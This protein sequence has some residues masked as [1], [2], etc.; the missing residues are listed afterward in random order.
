MEASSDLALA[1]V[2][3]RRPVTQAWLT[4]TRFS[5]LLGLMVI[6]AFSEVIFGGRSFFYRDFGLWAYPNAFHHR[7]RFWTGEV[8]LWNP[9]SSCGI[10][11]LAQWNTIT[12]YPFSLIYLLLPLPWSLNVFCLA[13]LWLAGLGMY[14]LALR[15]TRQPLAAGIAGLA[16]GL[17]GLTLHS[18]M[19]PNNLAALGWAPLVVLC[20]ERAWQ[21]GGRPIVPAAVLAATQ[22]LAGAPE[23]LLFTWCLLFAL[24]GADVLRNRRARLAPLGRFV[25]IA[26]LALGLSSIQLLPFVQLVS[27]S[28]RSAAF[29]DATWSM[30][31]WGVANFLVPLFHETKSVV[32]VYSQD[33]QQWT[34]SYY[35]GVGPL[36]LAILAL[37]RTNDRRTK[38]LAGLAAFGLAMSMG[39]NTPLFGWMKSLFPPLGMVRFPIKFV[40]LVVLTVPL[41]AA[42][43]ARRMLP[44]PDSARQTLRR[45]LAV[46]L[47]LLLAIGALA[48]S[49]WHQPIA[50]EDRTVTLASAL[51]R[52]V[53]LLLLLL[54]VLRQQRPMKPVWQ[55]AL[56][57]GLLATLGLDVLTHAPRQNPT[58]PT[59]ALRRGLGSGGRL[60][61][62]G[63]GRVMISAEVQD[64]ME[65]AATPDLLQY[66]LGQRRTLFANCNLIEGIA[67]VDG[68]FSL[69]LQEAARVH[70]LL[71]DTS[72]PLPAG[73]ADFLGVDAISSPRDRFGWQRRQTALPLVTAGQRIVP[74][75]TEGQLAALASP[76]FDSRAVVFLDST[77]G[78]PVQ[79]TDPVR[80][81][82][83]LRECSSHRIVASVIAPR[84]SLLVVAQAY[85]P[86]WRVTVNGV[87]SRLLRANLAFQGVLIP[88]GASRV[89]LWYDDWHFKRGGVISIL[90]TVLCIG[91]IVRGRIRAHA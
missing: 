36:A 46:W 13:H 6:L 75:A 31:P 56:Q 4:P 60:P 48:G 28:Q 62:L 63:A 27:L 12:L 85:H 82:T 43:G 57:L 50:G 88:A 37:C 55:A 81:E 40:V 38:L 65:Q 16:Y 58:I 45:I 29:A 83:E 3:S 34:S 17:N 77:T 90:S 52:G 15:W 26:A 2:G 59:A 42:C 76:A 21:R 87:E 68:M 35:L 79:A 89:V 41:L 47:L 64:F 80:T 66:Y 70:A 33:T 5:L 78:D 91:G 7:D 53:F 61:A 1:S 9:L 72:R 10:P 19:W 73:L 30:P 32:G 24:L 23:I 20:A 86:S 74:A 67:K 39:E 18:L 22:A 84:P 11:F 71:Y 51:S 14:L 54:W 8:P 49:A 69:H 44:S 25:S